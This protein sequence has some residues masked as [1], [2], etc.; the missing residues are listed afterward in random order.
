MRENYWQDFINCGFKIFGGSQEN[1]NDGAVVGW[2]LA[3]NQNVFDRDTFK[4]TFSTFPNAYLA[5]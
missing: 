4:S 3:L 1:F 5:L 2:E